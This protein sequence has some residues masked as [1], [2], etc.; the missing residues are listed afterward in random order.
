[1]A[2]DRSASTD[3][4][5]T[6]LVPIQAPNFQA[7]CREFPDDAHVKAEG[8]LRRPVMKKTSPN[9]GGIFTVRDAALSDLVH[10]GRRACVLI[11]S[12]CLAIWLS[13]D[14]RAAVPSTPTGLSP[15]GDSNSTVIAVGPKVTLNWTPV[16]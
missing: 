2:L 5:S 11:V 8:K 4:I 12:L 16:S 14:S 3:T 1:M 15:G 9:L 13:P 10:S 7:V 6:G